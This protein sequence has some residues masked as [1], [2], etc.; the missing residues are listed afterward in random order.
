MRRSPHELEQYTTHR[1]R[2][3]LAPQEDRRGHQDF[4]ARH[5]TPKHRL[6]TQRHLAPATHTEDHSHFPRAVGSPIPETQ[7]VHH[8]VLGS[9]LPEANTHPPTWH[10]GLQYPKFPTNFCIPKPPQ[11]PI[12]E[13]LHAPDT[14][15]SLHPVSRSTASDQPFINLFPS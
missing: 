3:E 14:H 7:L 10:W 1:P 2:Q 5:C 12:P 11:D 13:Y 8:Q 4:S 6:Q 15:T 9:S